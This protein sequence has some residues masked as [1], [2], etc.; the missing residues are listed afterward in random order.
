MKWQYH[1]DLEGIETLVKQARWALSDNDFHAYQSI[2]RL[3]KLAAELSES[4]AK[5]EEGKAE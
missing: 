3:I 2:M 4:A 1:K 5:R